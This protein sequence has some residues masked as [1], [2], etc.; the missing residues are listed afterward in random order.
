VGCGKC[1]GIDIWRVEKF[2]VKPWP[3][4]E[5]GT[6]YRGDCYLV[7]HTYKPDPEAPK[8]AWDV[9]FWLGAKSTQDEQGTAAYK[10]VELDD[11]FGDIP[12]QHREVDGFESERFLSLWHGKLTVQEG[13]IESGFHHVKPDKYEPRL[14]QFKGKANKIRV[15]QVPMSAASLNAGDT[16]LLDAGLHL[17]E[18]HGSGSAVA[19]RN[20]CRDVHI[21]LVGGRN[22]RPRVHTIDQ[23]D[24]V[25]GPVA[26]FWK[27]VGAPGGAEVAP[28]SPDNAVAPFERVLMHVTD[29]TGALVCTEEGRGATA[30]R[31]KLKTNDAYI[32]DVGHTVFVWVGDGASKTERHKA[33]NFA[34]GYLTEAR[35]PLQTPVVRLLELSAR[36]D[37]DRAWVD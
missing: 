3:K 16:F 19:E 28:A 29:A 25:E 7:L 10:A 20:K 5:F 22:G 30:T 14:L 36:A 21:G 11:L 32:L 12:V 27:L 37:F 17:Y 4:A 34:T 33:M 23:G 2:Q 1:Q 15:E 8:L 6:F 13:G 18:W 35:R 9:Y 31:D 24:P 26:D